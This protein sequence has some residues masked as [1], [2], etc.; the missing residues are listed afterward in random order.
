MTCNTGMYNKTKTLRRFITKLVFV[1]QQLTERAVTYSLWSEIYLCFTLTLYCGKHELVFLWHSCIKA[2]LGTVN[3]GSTLCAPYKSL[4]LLSCLHT[5]AA[6]SFEHSSLPPRQ[7]DLTVCSL[8]RPAQHNRLQPSM[9]ILLAGH[10]P[11][12]HF[13]QLSA[14]RH[15]AV[16]CLALLGMQLKQPPHAPAHNRVKC[17]VTASTVSAQLFCTSFQHSIRSQNQLLL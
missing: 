2:Q 6:P 12:P 11:P 13:P 3:T 14:A 15:W 17:D 7:L 9:R 1:D 10:L 4:T 16:C 5:T 8:A